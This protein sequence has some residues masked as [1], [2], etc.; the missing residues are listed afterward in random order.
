[1]VEI[2]RDER[3][4]GVNLKKT[5]GMIMENRV[6]RKIETSTVVQGIEIKEIRTVY[7]DEETN[8][9]L[10]EGWIYLNSGVVHHDQMGFNAKGYVR[11][12]RIK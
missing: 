5:R 2:K 12:G 4:P 11:L 1:M 3:D 10:K 9:L 6:V 8:K 7:T